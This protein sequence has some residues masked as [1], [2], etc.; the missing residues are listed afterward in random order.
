[1][2]LSDRIFPLFALAIM[3]LSLLSSC[4]LPQVS[5]EQRIFLDLSLDF[6]GQYELPKQKFKDTPVG[7][8]SA[9]V[10]DRQHLSEGTPKGFRFYALSDD[11][12]QFAPARFYTLKLNLNETG[13]QKV[14]VENV[15]FLKGEDNQT[16]PQGSIDLEGMALTPQNTLFISS[17]GVTNQGI[18]PFVREFDLQTGQ[19][20]Q[21][22]P[23]PERYI[24]D[25]SG[26][27]QLQGVQDNLGF[28]ALTLN[29]TGTIPAKGEPIRLFAATESALIQDRDPVTLDEQGKPKPQITKCRLLHY[30][31]GDGPASVIAEHLY[32]LAIPPEGARFDGL[33]E[34][35]AIDPA[36]HFLS[37][38]RSLSL[39]G[40][41]AQ[42]YQIATGGATDT[43]RVASLKGEVQGIEPVKKK[44]V[45]D[46]NQLGIPLDNLEAMTLGPRLPDGSQSLI[47]VS[48]DNFRDEQVTQFLLFRIKGKSL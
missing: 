23:I 30:Y 43:S 27:K 25:G 18:P 39:T 13:I 32:P 7:G 6:L 33:T 21:S 4:S 3:L 14:E 47:L 35:L 40:I 24:P 15:T 1:M 19:Q 16:Y 46:L 28:E 5:A 8:L 38:E 17:E 44:L 2:K 37:L 45:L 10:Y 36:G 12:S 41:N 42:I 31:I 29:P 26:D 22:L 34:L 11:R 48:D 20:K 9:L